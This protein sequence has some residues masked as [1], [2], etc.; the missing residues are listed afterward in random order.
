M[1]TQGAESNLMLQK[2]REYIWHSGG[3]LQDSIDPWLVMQP[4]TQVVSCLLIP[5]ILMAGVPAALC[6]CVNLTPTQL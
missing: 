1:S 4:V 2:L 3:N 6:T 5:M